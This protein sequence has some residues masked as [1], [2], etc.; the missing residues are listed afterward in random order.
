[1]R[2]GIIRYWVGRPAAE[3]ETIE[4]FKSAAAIIDHQIIELRP[5]GKTLEGAEADVDFVI[6]LHF[7]SGKSTSDLTYGA[8]WNP[9][10]FYHGWGFSKTFA[11]QISNDFLIS[12]GAK[13]IDA[14]FNGTGIPKIITQVLSHT[15][16]PVY[17]NP[18]KRNDR[19]LFY[20]GVNWEKSSSKHGR[21]HE[22]LKELDAMGILEIYG[23]E[24]LGNVR[25]W[26]G[27]KSFR[28]E[29][30]F[31]GFSVIEK[32]HEVGAVL[33]L[34]S[35]EH[36]KDQI[37]TSRLFEGLAGGAAIV[38]DRHHFLDNNFKNE[39]WQFDNSMTFKEQA[40]EIANILNSINAN[41]SET[42]AKVL[43]GQQVL[44]KSF[45]L[46][47]QL[48]EVV[49]HAREQL[50]R[51]EN[52]KQR[53]ATALVLLDI[54]IN[55]INDF[56]DSLTTAGFSKVIVIS[57]FNPCI[58]VSTS[59]V[60]K[61]LNS[62]S[63]YFEFVEE[64]RQIE[65]DS[66]FL[67]LFTGHERVFPNFLKSIDSMDE[68]AVAVFNTGAQIELSDDH[69]A[70]AINAR[71]ADWNTQLLASLVIKRLFFESYLNEF[72]SFSIHSILN[73][74]SENFENSGLV[75]VDPLVRFSYME[76]TPNLGYIQGKEFHELNTAVL[77]NWFPAVTT[78]LNQQVITNIRANRATE[79]DINNG[80]FLA[81][82]IYRAL[83]TPNWLTL[84]VRRFRHRI[85]R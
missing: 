82:T 68:S 50:K 34:S 30:P 52:K 51:K 7:A 41:P 20:I 35:Q 63:S 60:L 58:K 62:N 59:V 48:G 16:P 42:K 31:D 70:N 66:E 47:H 55:G 38:A 40:L 85:F 45:N 76:S 65:D 15:V 1:M 71:S 67:V 49:N 79:I 19:K 17:K 10:K 18:E 12:C 2:I 83:R 21:H 73:R 84:I 26:A 46:T 54:S 8:L 11:N 13:N 75:K 69:Y 74:F 4:R 72:Q 37:Q 36:L 3:H 27:F 39:I 24:K 29:L 44:E 61:C 23:P 64:Y 28:G 9:W 5:D 53:N 25:P 56:I 81:S 22:L 77:G 78:T 80:I 14:R 6:N 43:Q 33:V 32:C 57:N